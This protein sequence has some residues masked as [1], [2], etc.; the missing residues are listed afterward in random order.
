MK[1]KKLLVSAL[2]STFIL[3]VGYTS[4]SAEAAESSE[5]ITPFAVPVDASISP[6]RDNFKGVSSKSVTKNLS[7]GG[8]T[9]PYYNA[10]YEDG[11]TS[12]SFT[13]NY[14]NTSATAQYDLGPYS[15]YTW[16]NYLRVT[17]GSSATA[18]ASVI[19]TR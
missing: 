10:Y 8:G 18:S 15:T 14:Y 11:I 19:L 3:G 16:N 1:M 6:L 2:A 4:T 5:G 13:A 17:N 7:W 9:T 12:R